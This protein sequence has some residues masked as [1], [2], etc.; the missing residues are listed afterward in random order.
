MKGESF[1]KGA[2]FLT[3]SSFIIK[4]LGFI[5]VIPF[6]AMVGGDKYILFEYAYKPYAIFI[7]LS[8]L[9]LP[10]AFSK[11]IS[12]YREEN[13]FEHIRKIIISGLMIMFC[14]G[15]VSFVIMYASSEKIAEFLVG[16]G[17]GTGNQINEVVFVLRMVSF[18]LIIVPVLSLMR[19]VMQ[20]YKIMKATAYSQM[21]EQAIRILIILLGTFLIIRVFNKS[22]VLAV[23]VSTFAAFVSA[24]V[25]FIIMIYY[26]KKVDFGFSFK[27]KQ[28]LKKGSFSYKEVYKEVLVYAIPFVFV[29]LSITLVQTIDTFSIN[30]ILMLKGF[31]LGSAEIENSIV[32]L[33]QKLIVIPLSIGT[34]LS[35]AL[36]PFITQSYKAG[37]FNE[38]REWITKS[39]VM[40]L[41]IVLPSMFGFLLLGAPIFSMVFGTEYAIKGGSTMVAYSFTPI[42]YSMYSITAAILQGMNKTKVLMSSLIIGIVV[43]ILV[44]YPAIIMFDAEG[45]AISTYFSFFIMAAIQMNAIKKEA[46]YNW[47]ENILK[48]KGLAKTNIAAV[49]T[50]V[51]TA[52]IALNSNTYAD[53]F[54]YTTVSILLTV[55]VY[56]FFSIRTGYILQ[57]M[58]REK[59]ITRLPVVQKILPKEE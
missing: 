9:G 33:V 51:P 10:M 11:L 54:L 55:L 26:F 43:K 24:F 58:E 45:S 3:I 27:S 31:D 35:V 16:G 46:K 39:I 6:V 37:N 23:G 34:S 22:E 21:W 13:K 29:G 56:T 40:N 7:S 53:N 44:N 47:L 15:V 50:L 5:Y 49:V 41:F 57:L 52:L 18:A 1:L 19:G 42:F 4:I 14:L 20:G 38:I 25:A 12:K 28:T 36:V 30:K 32:S 48:I 2:M 17:N 8:T 59:I